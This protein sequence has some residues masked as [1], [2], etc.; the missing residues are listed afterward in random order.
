MGGL[1]HLGV[2]FAAKMGFKT[3]AIARGADKGPLA[4]KLGAHIY[5]DS[6]SQNAAEELNKLG[7]AEVILATVNDA[8]R[9]EC[10]GCHWRKPP[11]HIST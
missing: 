3:V 11:R 1:G 5:I 7:G 10:G 4:R 9:H 8:K 2:Q 6:T